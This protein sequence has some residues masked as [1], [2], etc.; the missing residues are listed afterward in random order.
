MVGRG[1]KLPYIVYKIAA[2]PCMD[3]HIT[4]ITRVSLIALT[5]FQSYIDVFLAK[6]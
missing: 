4:Y 5:S 6:F 3:T 1:A 2:M